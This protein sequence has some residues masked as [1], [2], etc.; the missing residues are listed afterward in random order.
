MLK[1]IKSKKLKIIIVLLV[2][3]VTAFIIASIIWVV[4]YNTKVKPMLQNVEKYGFTVR[5]DKELRCYYYDYHNEEDMIGYVISE[6]KFLEFFSDIQ[7]LTGH[8]TY[9]D[10]E[11]HVAESMT[12][13]TYYFS[14]CARPF[15]EG[16]YL[17]RVDDYTGVE[18]EYKDGYYISSSSEY[19]HIVIDKDMNFISGSKLMYDEHYDEL[20]KLYDDVMEIFGK[21]AFK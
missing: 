20:K 2:L 6:P 17:F 4:Y 14:Y 15:G 21:D 1:K 12:D 8:L 19:Y 3:A 5:E 7:V 16:D 11:N 18:E 10:L 13:Y 9:L